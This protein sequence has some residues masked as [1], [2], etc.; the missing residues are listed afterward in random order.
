MKVPCSPNEVPSI[1]STLVT[2]QVST[3]ISAH[4]GTGQAW[5]GTS[6]SLSTWGGGL[7]GAVG[8]QQWLCSGPWGPVSGTWFSTCTLRG[9][10]LTWKSG[11][12]PSRSSWALGHPCVA[13]RTSLPGQPQPRPSSQLGVDSL[14][15]GCLL[16]LCGRHLWADLGGYLCR[17]CPHLTLAFGLVCYLFPPQQGLGEGQHRTSSLCQH[18]SL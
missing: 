13:C 12:G 10:Q 18:S 3:S 5:A 17:A 7:V 1:A 6:D 4:T 16:C 11:S 14:A 9:A 8:P 2:H 15:H